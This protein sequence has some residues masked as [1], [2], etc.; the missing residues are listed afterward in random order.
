MLQNLISILFESFI[1]KYKFLLLLYQLLLYQIQSSQC[2]SLDSLL[3]ILLVFY[4]DCIAN[5]VKSLDFCRSTST[6]LLTYISRFFCSINCINNQIEIMCTDIK[7]CSFINNRVFMIHWSL[8]WHNV[9]VCQIG[10]PLSFVFLSKGKLLL[11]LE[12]A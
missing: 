3:I 11:L 9:P 6:W 5:Y 2:N 8:I 10:L 7:F 12:F 4:I 1:T